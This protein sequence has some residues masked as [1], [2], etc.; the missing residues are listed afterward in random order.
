LKLRT[1]PDIPPVSCPFSRETASAF[2][3]ITVN[4]QLPPVTLFPSRRNTIVL[5]PGRSPSTFRRRLTFSISVEA[6]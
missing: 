5:V 1:P 6:V 2:G 4:V 3:G